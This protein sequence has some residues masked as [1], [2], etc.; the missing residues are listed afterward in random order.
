[1]VFITELNKILIIALLSTAAEIMRIRVKLKRV[2]AQK[3]S[4]KSS[5]I[6]IIQGI[7]F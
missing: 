6:E 4:Y 3:R 7:L 1:M 2:R 5:G